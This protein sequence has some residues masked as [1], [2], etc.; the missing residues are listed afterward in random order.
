MAYRPARC[1]WGQPR[2]RRTGVEVLGDDP[3][4]VG[5]GEVPF[6]LE[7]GRRAFGG[8]VEHCEAQH[9]KGVP[10]MLGR[11]AHDPTYMEIALVPSL[12]GEFTAWQE[13]RQ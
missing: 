7:I 10:W 11:A 3:I 1:C 8:W 13:P 9:F 5:R 4:A 2:R 12:L 6:D